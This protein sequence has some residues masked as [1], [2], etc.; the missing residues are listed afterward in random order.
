[1]SDN[2]Q[3]DRQVLLTIFGEYPMCISEGC[4]NRAQ[5]FHHVTRRGGKRER[6]IHSSV[7]NACPICADCHK[8]GGIHKPE[9][10]RYYLL[11]VRDIVEKSGY[12]LTE[13]DKKFIEKY[14]DLYS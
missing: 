11:K 12:T 3:H 5:T 6:K 2:A 14:A 13:L 10:R 8:K 4:K 7:F 9:V 1:M